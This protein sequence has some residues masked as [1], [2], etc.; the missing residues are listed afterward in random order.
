[1]KNLKSKIDSFFSAYSQEQQELLNNLY[2]SLVNELTARRMHMSS[3]AGDRLGKLYADEL[4]NRIKKSL[5]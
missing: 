5:E 4:K 1:M 2:Q 3:H